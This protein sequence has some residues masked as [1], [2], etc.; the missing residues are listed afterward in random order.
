MKTA[1][2][3]GFFDGVHLGHRKLLSALRAKPHATIFTFSNHP[4]SLLAP[5]APPLLISVEERIRLLTDFADEV[6]VY[7]F[8]EELAATPFDLLLSRFDLSHIVLGK[9]SRFGKDQGGTE[10]AVRKWA[11]PRGIIVEYI[12]ILLVNGEPVSSS[13]IRKALETKNQTLANQLLGKS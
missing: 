4:K 10:Q 3:I 8:T 13:R 9:G 12:P 11:E 6:M 2:T 7:P 1:L 5:P